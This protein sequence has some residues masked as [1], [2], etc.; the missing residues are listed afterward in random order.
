MKVSIL[1][2]V[3]VTL[4]FAAVGLLSL[5]SSRAADSGS[6]AQSDPMGGCCGSQTAEAEKAAPPVTCGPGTIARGGQCVGTR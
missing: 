5:S 3:V 1:R 4:S 6:S 2:A